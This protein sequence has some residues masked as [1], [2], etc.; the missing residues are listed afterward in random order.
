MNGMRAENGE[1]ASATRLKAEENVC[2]M[3]GELVLRAMTDVAV[4][5]MRI[6]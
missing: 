6:S 5:A 4:V 2:W 3:R 1:T